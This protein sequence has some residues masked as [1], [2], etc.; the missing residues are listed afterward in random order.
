MEL[1]YQNLKSKN[2][3]SLIAIVRTVTIIGYIGFAISILGLVLE[4][5]SVS[6]IDSTLLFKSVLLMLV[7]GFFAFLI[8][9]EESYRLQIELAKT[10]QSSDT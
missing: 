10:R 2:L 5:F 3:G 8:S 4:A 6:Y 9:I 7:A 1:P